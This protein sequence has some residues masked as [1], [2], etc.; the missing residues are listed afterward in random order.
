MHQEQNQAVLLAHMKKVTITGPFESGQLICA[1][2]CRQIKALFS[3][4]ITYFNCGSGGV[5]ES[6]DLLRISTESGTA[7]IYFNKST[8]HQ[9]LTSSKDCTSHEERLGNCAC[10]YHLGSNQK[11]YSYCIIPQFHIPYSAFYSFT[12]QLYHLCRPCQCKLPQA[13][14]V[15]QVYS[16]LHFSLL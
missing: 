9:K 14:D 16:K 3:T 1:M 2:Q 11:H 6:L 15:Q 4:K 8:Q 7:T 5:S 12:Y 10:A 13:T